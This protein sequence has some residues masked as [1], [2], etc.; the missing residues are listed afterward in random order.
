MNRQLPTRRP[1]AALV[2]LTCLAAPFSAG[3]GMLDKW[4]KKGGERP[5]CA[6][7][8]RE[9]SLVFD[10]G[11]LAIDLS[12]RWKLG[13]SVL[14]FGG[15]SE[16]LQGSV[17]ATERNLRMGQEARV[18]GHRLADGTV[19]VRRLRVLTGRQQINDLGQ[20]DGLDRAAGPAP[21]GEPR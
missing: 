5:D 20:L 15:S 2:I 8:D 19:L 9:P 12:G 1:L 11:T 21:A 17:E 10:G 18:T 3:A 6:R 7:Y 13:G 16:I 14:V 4:F